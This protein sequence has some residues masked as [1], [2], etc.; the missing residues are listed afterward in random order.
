MH[1]KKRHDDADKKNI[2]KKT[3]KITHH[4]IKFFLGLIILQKKVKYTLTFP[5]GRVTR[6]RAD[7]Q[8]LAREILKII[9]WKLTQFLVTCRAS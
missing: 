8:C 7:R 5:L 2:L 9:V 6:Q 3:H 1:H 4:F